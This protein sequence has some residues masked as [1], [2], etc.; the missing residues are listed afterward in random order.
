MNELSFIFNQ[1]V[2]Q[3]KNQV[4]PL[5][6]SDSDAGISRTQSHEAER[7]HDERAELAKGSMLL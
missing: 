3:E 2:T 4:K 1:T 5:M 6:R 7:A